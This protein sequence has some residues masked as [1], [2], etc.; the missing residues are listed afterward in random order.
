MRPFLAGA[1]T[2]TMVLAITALAVLL[3]LTSPGTPGTVDDA[4]AS[5]GQASEPSELGPPTDLADGATWLGRVRLDASDVLSPD[6]GFQDVVAD[7]SD[8]ILDADGLTAGR[9]HLTATL[10]FATAAEQIGEEVELYAA[11]SGRAGVRRQIE[12]FG[13]TL[14]VAA[15]GTV[16]VEAGQLVI[17]PEQVD[18]GGPEWV[19]TGLS[20]VARRLVTIRHSVQGLPQGMTLRSVAVVGD[21]FRATLTGTEVALGG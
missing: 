3:T 6:G 13:R 2:A 5:A 19:D 14:P 18:L 7:G 17:E 12:L 11:E 16:R 8:V 9:L 4:P 21:G 15:T 1:A 10:P 20:A